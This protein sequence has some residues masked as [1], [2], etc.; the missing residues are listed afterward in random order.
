M[1]TIALKNGAIAADTQVTHGERALRFEDKIYEVGDRLVT[2]FGSCIQIND[3]A[4]WLDN[5]AQPECWLED[6]N[7]P[8]IYG[9]DTLIIVIEDDGHV[10]EVSQHGVESIGF[11]EQY[12]W[13]TGGEFALGALA[14]GAE[15]AAAVMIAAKFDIYTGGEVTC[16]DIPSG[17]TRRPDGCKV[18]KFKELV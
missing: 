10:I 15:A 2:G 5:L 18:T 13:G 3:F 1:T 6:T 17:S 8:Q 4:A 11:P 14:A 7:C 12:S 16:F 9:D